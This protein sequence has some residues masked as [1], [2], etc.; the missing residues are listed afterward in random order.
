MIKKTLTYKDFDGNEVTEEHYFHLS[1]N[2]L[3]L[4]ENETDGGLEK[5]LNETTQSGDAMKILAKFREFI[6]KSYGQR[7]SGT[8]FHKSD[9]ITEDFL[10]SLAYEALLEELV[11][12]GNSVN[13]TEFINGLIPS[14]L[15]KQSVK[16]EALDALQ[17][18]KVAASN[19]KGLGIEV[20][21]VPD[22]NNLDTGAGAWPRTDEAADDF[23]DRLQKDRIR[24]GLAD[25]IDRGTN[26]PLP[27]AFREP[28]ER[29]L[30]VMPTQRMYDVYRRKASG[31]TPPAE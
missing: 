9:K 8:K 2:E 31:W 12:S 22:P 15:L 24:S 27:W 18:N 21:H 11:M 29:E 1:V 7:E 25:H 16:K 14:S 5:F 30:V 13:V 6:G 28:T 26:K 10:D 17:Q 20:S 4:I 23:Q 19:L 3:M